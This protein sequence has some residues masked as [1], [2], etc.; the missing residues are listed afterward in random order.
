VQRQGMTRR[1]R[2]LDQR[3]RA[4]PAVVEP[5]TITISSVWSRSY[6]T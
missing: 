2:R 4:P 3:S 5:P 6:N 1:G